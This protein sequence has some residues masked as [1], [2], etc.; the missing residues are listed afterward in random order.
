[1]VLHCNTPTLHSSAAP[2]DARTTTGGRVFV[3]QQAILLVNLGNGEL[4]CRKKILKR[5]TDHLI[6][7]DLANLKHRQ[8]FDIL[9]KLF[10]AHTHLLL[11]RSYRLA[12]PPPPRHVLFRFGQV[13]SHGDSFAVVE[14]RWDPVRPVSRFWGEFWL[15]LEAF[16][17]SH[18]VSFLFWTQKRSTKKLGSFLC[19]G[20]RGCENST[21][22]SS[23]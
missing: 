19:S 15:G 6:F 17:K 3:L 20:A 8:Y 4:T 18:H 22:S 13:V 14:T 23:S 9:R 12:F 2:C 7:S 10:L 21:I 11:Y 5:L 1:M 16:V